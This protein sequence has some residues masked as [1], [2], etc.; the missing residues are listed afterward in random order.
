ME[1]QEGQNTE[2]QRGHRRATIDYASVFNVSCVPL[3][4][5]CG[6][7][8]IWE[9]DR[10]SSIRYCRPIKFKFMKESI[11]N[12]QKEYSYYKEAIA[13]LVPKLIDIDN[14]SCTVSYEL[15]LTMI[16]GKTSNAISNQRSSGSC[17]ICLARP[18]EM[19]KLEKVVDKPIKEE[20]LQFGMSTLHCKIRFM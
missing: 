17:N 16:D 15:K 6:E 12:I 19:N 7:K 9:N 14:F 20:L 8:T 3:E 4:L 2:N 11:E 13:N 10:P 5:K 18:S 1:I